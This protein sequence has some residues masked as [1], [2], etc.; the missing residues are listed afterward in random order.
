MRL[1]LI[2]EILAYI[3]FITILIHYRNILFERGFLNSN[4]LQDAC[5]HSYKIGVKS[6][7]EEHIEN[8]ENLLDF[9][10]TADIA[11]ADRRQ[12]NQCVVNAQ[13]IEVEIA[14]VLEIVTVHPGFVRT[15]QSGLKVP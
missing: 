6:N 1:N 4:K 3:H 11:I 13:Q 5:E 10:N 7:S 15:V 9:C 12:S 8:G 14:V 2:F